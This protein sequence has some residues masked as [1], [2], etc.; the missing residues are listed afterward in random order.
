MWPECNQYLEKNNPNCWWDYRFLTIYI[1]ASQIYLDYAEALFEG[2]G[3]ATA[4]IEGCPISAAEAINILRRRIGLTDLPSDIVADPDK[5]R[6]AYRRERA[7]ELMFENHRWWDIRRW[8]IADQT[9]DIYGVDITKKE[10]G[11]FS[12]KK[13]LVEKRIFKDCMY[14]YPIP[15]SER[16]INP[17]LEQNPGW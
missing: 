11:S 12:Y 3:S 13:V 5:F 8:M 9:T 14:L 15:Q 10:D 6:A 7:V 2:C 17:E 16:Y 1:R 4:T